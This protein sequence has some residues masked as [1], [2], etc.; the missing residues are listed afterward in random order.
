M[1]FI[2]TNINLAIAYDPSE[3]YESFKFGFKID[4]LDMAKI[5]N[6]I[7]LFTSAISNFDVPEYL[8]TPLPNAPYTIFIKKTPSSIEH[9]NTLKSMSSWSIKN[10]SDFKTLSYYDIQIY[11]VFLY[12]KHR[13][14]MLEFSLRY[15]PLP[16][17]THN[18][19]YLDP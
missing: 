18:V 11:P 2:K 12:F 7:I 19:Y 16:K 8:T 10:L 13:S 6:K 4:R 3:M 17:I 15:Y 1:G 14:D 9:I 5:K